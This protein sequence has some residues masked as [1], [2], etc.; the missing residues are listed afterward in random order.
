MVYKVNRRGPRT[1]PCG[2]PNSS[3]HNLERVDPILIDWHQW[4]KQEVNHFKVMLHT[5]NYDLRQLK[6]EVWSI[7]LNATDRLSKAS[8]VGSPRD[9][10]R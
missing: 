9:S 6:R 10:E 8:A 3:S 2:T 5:P 4:L 1:E 7:V